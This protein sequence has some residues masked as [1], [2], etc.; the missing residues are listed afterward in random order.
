MSESKEEKKGASD[1][2][3]TLL[4]EAQK[5]REEVGVRHVTSQ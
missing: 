2:S 4:A 5:L 1:E 3:D